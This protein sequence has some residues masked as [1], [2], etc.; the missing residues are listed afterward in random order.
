MTQLQ[1]SKKTQKGEKSKKHYTKDEF[2][3]KSQ[4]TGNRNIC[5]IGHNF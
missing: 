5:V 2:F 4:K 1:K 3:T